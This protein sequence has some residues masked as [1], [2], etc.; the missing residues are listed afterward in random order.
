MMEISPYEF[1][2][3]P[4]EEQNLLTL[5]FFMNWCIQGENNVIISTAISINS[6]SGMKVVLEEKKWV[7]ISN[8]NDVGHNTVRTSTVCNDWS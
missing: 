5:I 1:D 3:F 4:L 7:V 6:I 2:G 8:D